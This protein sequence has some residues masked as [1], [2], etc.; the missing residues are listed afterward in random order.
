LG[1]TS[2]AACCGVVGTNY[3]ADG[4]DASAARVGDYEGVFLNRSRN[5]FGAI[6]DGSSNTI[7]FGEIGG[8][9]GEEQEPYESAW[10]WANPAYTYF[11]WGQNRFGHFR[12]PHPATI[13]FAFG[14]GSVRALQRKMH[15][16]PSMTSVTATNGSF[17]PDQEI[18]F[19][20]ALSGRADGVTVN[21]EDL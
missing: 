10:A 12:S 3:G 14:D 17:V 18:I 8:F 19:T 15:T 4:P 1:R 11:G 20:W 16:P 7:L 2:Y 13:N 5:G 6:S 9:D 21:S